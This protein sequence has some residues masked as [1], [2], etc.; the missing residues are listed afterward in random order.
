MRVRLAISVYVQNLV[1]MQG[2]QRQ[3]NFMAT[4]IANALLQV[5][6]V[7]VVF[8]VLDHQ[9]LKLIIGI[10]CLLYWVMAAGLMRSAH[11]L[12]MADKLAM[13]Y[14]FGFLLPVAAMLLYLWKVI[15]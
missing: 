4:A 14:G 3:F 1:A 12:R 13:L 10:D 5:I 2:S 7:S 11:Q 15:I 9:L 6:V 8:F